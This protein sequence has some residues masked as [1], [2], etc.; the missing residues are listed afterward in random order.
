MNRWLRRNGSLLVSYLILTAAAVMAAGPLVIVI[1]ASLKGQYEI[2]SNTAALLPE[3]F[4]LYWYRDLLRKT[5]F[6][7]YVKNSLVYSSLSTIL[8]MAI[9]SL[10][11][12][13][14]TRFG[15][16][17]QKF[18]TRMIVM[19]YLFPPILLAIPYF[20]LVSNLGLANSLPGLLM[21][22]LSFTVPFC[23]YL[24]VSYFR[25]VPRDIEDA[26]MIDGL[27]R[28]GVFFHIALPLVAPGLVATAIFAFINAWNEFLYSLL[29]ISS[30]SRQTVSV[31]L[32]SLKVQLRNVNR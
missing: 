16:K 20:I 17:K 28:P 27:T 26:A 12:Y 22:Y 21:A 7:I 4:S 11:A 10:A 6:L 19:T 31:G 13:A 14:I 29:I 8:G 24:L 9:S 5:D 3:T 25:T 23:T 18:F 32:Y 30:G 15:G 1:F 2:V